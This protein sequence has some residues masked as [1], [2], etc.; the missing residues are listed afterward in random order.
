MGADLWAFSGTDGPAVAI[1]KEGLGNPLN[2]GVRNLQATPVGLFIGT[3]NASNLLTDPASPLHAGGW[4]LLRLG[5]TTQTT[6][7]TP[8]AAK[9]AKAVDRAMASLTVNLGQASLRTRLLGR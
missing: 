7:T 8:T 5:V 3:A 6:Q 1:S 9:Q 2:H 4:E